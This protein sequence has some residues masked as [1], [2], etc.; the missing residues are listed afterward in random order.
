MKLQ[1]TTY[2]CLFQHGNKLYV[3][4]H[5]KTKVIWLKL[6]LEDIDII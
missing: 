2:Y 1:N 4:N 5:S 3:A 6:L